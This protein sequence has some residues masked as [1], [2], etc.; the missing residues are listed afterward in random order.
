LTAVYLSFTIS[1]L[2]G[3]VSVPPALRLP[4]L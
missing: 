3:G 4:H 2:E 1:V